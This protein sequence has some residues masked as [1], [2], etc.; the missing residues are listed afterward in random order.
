MDDPDEPEDPEFEPPEIEDPEN[1][2]PEIE[3][4]EI[5]EPEVEEPEVEEPEIEQPEIEDNDVEE[6][7]IEDPDVE[8]SDVVEPEV[9]EPEVEQPETEEPGSDIETE[10]RGGFEDGEDAPEIEG[11]DDGQDESGAVGENV[12]ENEDGVERAAEAE[13]DTEDGASSA[14][15]ETAGAGESAETPLLEEWLADVTQAQNP[16]YDVDG[17]PVQRGEIIAVDLSDRAARLLAER[18]FTL[19]ETSRLAAIGARLSRLSVPAGETALTGLADARALDRAGVY[20]LGHYYGAPYAASGAG[21]A[22]SST[23]RAGRGAGA[24]NLRIGMIDSG[25]TAGQITALGSAAIEQKDFGSLVRTQATD[26]GTAV[27]AILNRFGA[28]RLVV[29]N[30]FQSDGHGNFTSAET[31]SRALDW[32]TGKGVGVINISLTGPRNLVLDAVVERALKRGTVIVA[33]AGNNGPTAPPAYPAAL[34]GVV[35]VTAVDDRQHV[36]RYANRGPYIDFAAHGVRVA[37]PMGDGTLREYTGTSFSAP[38][39]AAWLAAC[40]QDGRAAK[41][42]LAM[43]ESTAVDLG[44]PGRDEVYGAGYID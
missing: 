12:G 18:G 32:L 4:P 35:A 31:I 14:Q 42:C 11:S 25:V 24:R 43:L 23:A 21:S 9:E 44:R 34:P 40:R 29:A 36:Y 10:D 16:E 20:D 13:E 3:D 38:R 37:V 5:E 26:H 2:P 39:I 19:I 17:F 41:S 28:D 30:V 8:E 22:A 27:A 7:E 15:T 33:A 1:E 6:P